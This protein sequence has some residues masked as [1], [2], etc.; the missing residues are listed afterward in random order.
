MSVIIYNI[1][2]TNNLLVNIY[3]QPAFRM[4]CFLRCFTFITAEMI[5]ANRCLDLTEH[6]AAERGHYKRIGK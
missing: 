3:F 1:I 5:S 4:F 2:H 6:C